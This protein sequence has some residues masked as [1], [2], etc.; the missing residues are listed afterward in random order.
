[1][2]VVHVDEEEELFQTGRK[3]FAN[4]KLSEEIP[5]VVV[6]RCSIWRV[7]GRDAAAMLAIIKF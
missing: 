3:Q 1:M 6:G 2:V 7:E 5:I 4:K